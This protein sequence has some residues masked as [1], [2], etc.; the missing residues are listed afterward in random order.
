MNRSSFTIQVK[1]YCRD[2]LILIFNGYLLL[3]NIS[4]HYSTARHH[5]LLIPIAGI[6]RWTSLLGL[7]REVRIPSFFLPQ[8]FWPSIDLDLGIS[9]PI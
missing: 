6:S 7:N 3:Y 5:K 4:I 2:I 8:G 1:F 9:V